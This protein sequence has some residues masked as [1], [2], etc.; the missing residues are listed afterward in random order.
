MST[1][2]HKRGTQVTFGSDGT[3]TTRSGPV[4]KR[5]TFPTFVS[6]I[7]PH[8]NEAASFFIDSPDDFKLFLESRNYRSVTF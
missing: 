7:D 2:Y 1:L 4:V 5:H 3:V 6:T 8:T